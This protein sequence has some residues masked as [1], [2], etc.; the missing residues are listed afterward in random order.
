MPSYEKLIKDKFNATIQ[1]LDFCKTF[2][3]VTNINSF[4]A[5]STNNAIKEILTSDDDISAETSLILINAIN[6]IVEEDDWN[7]QSGEEWQCLGIPYKNRKAWLY[8]VLPKKSD[9]LL[10]VIEKIDYTFI[11]KCTQRKK[12]GKMTVILPIIEISSSINLDEKLKDMGIKKIFCDTADLS[13]IFEKGLSQKIEKIIHKSV[14]KIDE[15]GT[16][17]SAATG[18]QMNARSAPQPFFAIHPFLFFITS[19]EGPAS[20]EPK[21][22]LFMGTFC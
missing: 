15:K 21:D 2:D 7:F 19:V 17:A 10:S 20:A 3:A 14:I 13:G 16:E 18:F 9:G 1:S 12:T 4:V 11:K 8:I 22:I 6:F 5:D